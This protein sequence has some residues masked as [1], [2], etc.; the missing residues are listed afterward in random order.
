MTA[1]GA[2]IAAEIAARGPIPFSRFMEIALYDAECGYYRGKRDPFGPGGDFFTASQLQPVFGRL[3]AAAMRA[4]RAE[5]GAGGKFSVVEWGAGRGDLAAA[6]SEFDYH[7][8][9]VGRGSPPERFTG[10]VFANELFDALPVDV[11]RCSGGKWREMR[12]GL[13]GAGCGWVEGEVAALRTPAVD[14]RWRELPVRMRETL[15]AM[16]AGLER[17]FVLVIDYG[18]TA[19]ELERFPQGSLMAYRR[20]QALDEIFERPGEQDLTAHVDWEA[21]T[22][23]AK[24]AGLEM[25]RFETMGLWLLRAGERDEFAGALAAESEAEAAA[26]REQLKTLL[27]SMGE[28]F[29]VGLWRK[30]GT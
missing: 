28:K 10:V 13:A 18:Y 12:V 6:L 1:A 22:R 14:G 26:L 4:L 27:F 25:V 3:V 9:D 23:C 8:V 30:G 2:K 5:L 16:A 21:L 19:R 15:E 7:A 17:G 11:V 29:R 24:E 20:H